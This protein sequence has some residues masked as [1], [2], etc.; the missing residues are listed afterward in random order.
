ML[1]LYDIKWLSHASNSLLQSS[2]G[3]RSTQKL[4]KQLLLANKQFFISTFREINA[5]LHSYSRQNRPLMLVTSWMG[6]VPISTN[7]VLMSATW[8]SILVLNGT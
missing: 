1:M 5:V 4:Y 7:T 2:V 3:M 8:E 6:T